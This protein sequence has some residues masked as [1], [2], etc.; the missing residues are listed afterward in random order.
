[1]RSRPATPLQA[2]SLDVKKVGSS[3]H[4][5]PSC[6]REHWITAVISSSSL[7]LWQNARALSTCPRTMGAIGVQEEAS[8]WQLPS[9]QPPVHPHTE[10]KPDV[11]IRIGMMCVSG[12][13]SS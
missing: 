11:L 5:P 13:R 12:P 3:H 2:L 6:S 10:H 1:M 9:E 7:C 4:L 8:S